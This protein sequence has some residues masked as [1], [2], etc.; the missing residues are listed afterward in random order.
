MKT[1]QGNRKAGGRNG[2]AM[3]IVLCL[4]GVMLVATFSIVMITGSMARKAT[5]ISHGVQ[6]L[7]IAEA[8]VADV[9]QQMST[10]Y[11]GML[12]TSYQS[13]FA[14]GTFVVSTKLDMAT[15]SITIWSD[16]E[17]N[18]EGRGTVVELLGDIDTIRQKALGS[19]DAILAEGDVTLE[20]AALDINGSVHANRN[21]YHSHG[22]T[23]IDGDVSACGVVEVDV[24]GGHQKLPGS[25][26]MMVPDFQPFDEWKSEAISG[27]IYYPSSTHIKNKNVIQPANGILYVDG[28]VTLANNTKIIGT[29]VAS[30]SI[31][32]DNRL[33]QTPYNVNWP[34]LLA[35]MNISLHNR[36]AYYGVIF[37]GHDIVSRNNRYIQG[38]LVAL[39]NVYVE[40]GATIDPLTDSPHWSPNQSNTPPEVVV[41]GW[42]R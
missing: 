35:G 33:E 6:A 3:V 2:S 12:D 20:T 19:G 13:S 7:A 37:A 4:A 42:L 38:A 15:G 1:Q 14:G 22:N 10:N 32:I 36:N 30:G 8:G 39:N 9:L 25:G 28:D 29:I 16:G 31:T 18:G 34:A 41:G 27:G 23:I 11:I 5:K 24:T 40:G 21:V 26:P 17:Y